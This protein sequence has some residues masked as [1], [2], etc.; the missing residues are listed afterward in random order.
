MLA[1]PRRRLKYLVNKA[2]LEESSVMR[3]ADNGAKVN[4]NLAVRIKVLRGVLVG[5]FAFR[6]YAG[7]LGVRLPV[8]SIKGPGAGPRPLSDTLST[9]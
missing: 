9:N 1:L 7:Y 4:Q 5:T 3:K 6:T 8:A 2:F